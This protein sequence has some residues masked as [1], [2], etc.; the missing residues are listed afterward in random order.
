VTGPDPARLA[1][2]DQRLADMDARLD[3]NA[4]AIMR[5]DAVFA[6]VAV[7]LIVIEIAARPA[8]S[9]WQFVAMLGAVTFL[10]VGSFFQGLMLRNY[11]A[12][13]RDLRSRV[14]NPHR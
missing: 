7:A 1:A 9:R 2:L 8:L 11:R 4:R 6:G 10:C 14:G 3:R 12:E 5:G 13:I